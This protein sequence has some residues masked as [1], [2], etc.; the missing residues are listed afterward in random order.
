MRRAI[1]APA[2]A[3]IC[4]LAASCSQPAEETPAAATQSP[5]AV[6]QTPAASSGPAQS[7]AQVAEAFM[8]ATSSGDQAAFLALLTAKARESLE[9]AGD[10]G[11]FTGESFD[12]YTIGDAAVAGTEATVPVHAVQDG[13]PQNA[14][15]K[16]RQEDGAWRVYG[17]AMEMAPGSEITINLERVGEMVEQMAT[18][19]GDAI[20]QGFEQAMGDWQPGGSD[21]EIARAAAAFDALAPVSAAEYESA[22]KVSKDF[23]GTPA[24]EAL[25]QL[26]GSMKLTVYPGDHT[27]AL[28]KNVDVDTRGM[29]KLEAIER[30]AGAAGLQPEF[31]D[32]S[33]YGVLQSMAEGFGEA[34]VGLVAGDDPVLKIEGVE[35]EAALQEARAE[36]DKFKNA[37]KNA[38]TFAPRED[39]RRV[40]FAGPFHVRVDSVQ[41]NAPHATGSLT[42]VAAAYGLPEPIIA[43][44]GEVGECIVLAA[45]EDAKG[46]ALIDM[47]VT[48][49]GGGQAA[50]S[51]YVDTANRDL[52]NL[53]RDVESIEKISG[54]VNL[55]RP[56]EVLEFDFTSMQPDTTVENGGFRFTLT[57]AGENT[58][59]K[60]GVPQGWE[61][62]LAAKMQPYNADGSPM[63]VMYSDIT[64]WGD[65]EGFASVNTSGAPARVRIKLVP[66]VEKHS[67]SFELGP[68]ALA[69]FS[70]MPD[71]LEELSFAG[72]DAPISLAFVKVTEPDESFAKVLIKIEN[73]S[74][75]APQ[76]AF[77][78]FIYRDAAG[79]EIESF[80]H[81]LNGEFSSD[82]WAPLVQPGATV[83]SEQT[84]FQMP[85]NAASIDF[86]VK[87]LDFLDGTT[88]QAEN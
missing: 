14:S 7:P 83:E 52:K 72:H 19:L 67:Y 66:K 87:S 76:S 75:K 69:H 13:E 20:G 39:G 79:N 5:T 21:E 30:I 11:G 41:E 85:A 17:M 23:R 70:E 64:F 8:Q 47:N 38:I 77:V 65:D 51:A 82:G 32:L 40:V 42:V 71:K 46:R 10:N 62:D 56:A 9:S 73:H 59:F 81:T 49:F 16:M 36:F 84:A 15:L 6:T 27:S 86:V 1:L 68:V 61:G 25:A 29:S 43:T 63:G 26:A 54:S 88:W 4:V 22:W 78:D 44:T 28:A 18:A 37:P 74:N 57:E 80:P 35:A 34:L 33:D 12:S 2:F 3:T 31:P 50:G 53:L 58:Q 55:A 24:A 45:V 60:V 48:Y